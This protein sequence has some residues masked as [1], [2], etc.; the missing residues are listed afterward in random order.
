VQKLRTVIKPPASLVF[1]AFKE[2][3]AYRELLYFFACR[4]I[5]VKYKQTILG[6]GWAIVQPLAFML[7]FTFVFYKNLHLQSNQI[8]YQVFVLSGMILWNLF[9]T[10]VSNSSE[11]IVQSA[12]MIRKIYFPRL[13][14][15]V[16][17]LFVALLDFLI[18]M[19]LFF[20]VCFIYKQQLV[21]QSIFYIPLSILILCI[22]AIGTGLWLSALIVRF[23]DFR[24]LLPFL[25]QLFFFS[26]SVVYSLESIRQPVLKNLLA[27]NPIN[28]AIQLFRFSFKGNSQF[29]LP[30]ISIASA[31]IISITGLIYF[32]KTEA[33][34]ADL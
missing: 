2:F 13:I 8:P 22:A 25:L 6:I 12:G 21:W 29:E 34:F 5:T 24:Y 27:F 16:S 10:T 32:R 26:S 1:P 33:Y 30:V 20:V 11:S 14:I 28:G 3:W 17:T 18:T 19:V 23:K 7:L 4:D 9:Q 31:L 15:P